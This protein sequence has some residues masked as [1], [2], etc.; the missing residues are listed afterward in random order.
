MSLDG[1]L[2]KNGF[3]CASCVLR[4][5]QYSLSLDLSS[6]EIADPYFDFNENSWSQEDITLLREYYYDFMNELS[7]EI[8]GENI[9][10]ANKEDADDDANI[11]NRHEDLTPSSIAK[12]QL[13]LPSSSECVE[14]KERKQDRLFEAFLFSKFS[15]TQQ[16]FLSLKIRIGCVKFSIKNWTF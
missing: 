14:D 13:S 15:H 10:K 16:K 4:F 6:S 9:K 1:P 8:Y 11:N 3:D 7:D 12:K 5:Y 2:Q